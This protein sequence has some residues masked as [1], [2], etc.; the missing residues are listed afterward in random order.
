[1]ACVRADSIA[2]EAWD[3]AGR[4]V[5]FVCV[6]L[7][8]RCDIASDARG[9]I[10]GSLA[11]LF[12]ASETKRGTQQRMVSRRLF[13]VGQG[14]KKYIPRGKANSSNHHDHHRRMIGSYVQ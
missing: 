7:F 13:S 8:A 3:Q 2:M 12:A 10:C 9:L 6:E 5:R 14:K 4:H 1:M 11:W